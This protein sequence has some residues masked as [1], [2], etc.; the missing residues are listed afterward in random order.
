[1]RAHAVA[2]RRR[3]I[4]PAINLAPMLD[5]IFNL[6]FFFILA[7]TIRNESFVMDIN[8][9]ESK[10]ADQPLPRDPPPTITL[11]VQGEMHFKGRTM[12]REELELELFDLAARG[13]KEIM[14][15]GDRQVD[16]GRV[17]EV[18]DLCRESGLEVLLQLLPSPREDALP[19]AR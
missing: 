7:T 3:R 13:H 17:H 9:P 1:M 14:I 10:T 18:I 15:G 16:Y 5:V 12:V 2:H 4:R 11:N 6:I 8:L 19:N